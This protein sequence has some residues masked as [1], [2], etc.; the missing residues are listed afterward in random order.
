[1]QRSQRGFTLIEL[2]I[3]V[4]IIAILAA[5]A[6]PNFL[7]A[8]T[9]AK[10]S[11]IKNDH[12]VIANA[13]ELYFSEWN[14]YPE[15]NDESMLAPGGNTSLSGLVR[16]TTPVAYIT[17]IPLDPFGRERSGEG[18]AGALTYE[19]ASTGCSD[20]KPKGWAIASCG[21]DMEDNFNPGVPRYPNETLE[22]MLYDATNGTK[23]RG[24]EVRFGPRPFW[25][26]I[27]FR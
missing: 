19:M 8:Q 10:L 2:L 20:L 1:M 18:S 24:D 14:D 16:L 13:M 22:V 7:E 3:V 17:S 15:R 25:E 12:R 23:S 4:A 26:K 27:R 5:I 6:V 9:R 21:P 11:R